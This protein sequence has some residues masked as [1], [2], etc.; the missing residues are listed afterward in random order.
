MAIT[1]VQSAGIADNA[2][3][4]AHINDG[5]VAAA[6]IQSG[7]VTNTQGMIHGFTLDGSTG[8]LSWSSGVTELFDA[9]L[10]DLY[11]ATIVG[12]DDMTF[13]VNS[14]GHLIMTIG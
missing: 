7:A 2:I 1:T 12:T 10:N 14:N 3:T 8:N 9:Q 6:D 13:S 5:A 4:S 11:D